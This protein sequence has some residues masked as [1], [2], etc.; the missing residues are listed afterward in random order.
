MNTTFNNTHTATA[1]TQAE[2]MID[3]SCDDAL[4]LAAF[5]EAHGARLRNTADMVA[6]Y[7]KA[8]RVNCY[9]NRA[10]MLMMLT[11]GVACFGSLL[12]MLAR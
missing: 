7:K 3:A 5:N 11:T 2:A 10:I 6:Q 9:F 12:T 1:M 8:Q 4:D